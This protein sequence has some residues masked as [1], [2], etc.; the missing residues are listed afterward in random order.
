VREA[1]REALR[2][3]CIKR[4]IEEYVVEER[5]AEERQ[6]CRSTHHHTLIAIVT[7]KKFLGGAKGRGGRAKIYI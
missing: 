3:A 5:Q 7:H 4:H 6:A 2:K 1:A